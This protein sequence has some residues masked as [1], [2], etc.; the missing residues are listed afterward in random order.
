M[1]YIQ[2]FSQSGQP[3]FLYVSETAPHWPLHALPEDIDKY[4]TTYQVGWDQIREKRYHKLVEMG[5][6]DP[7][8]SPLSPRINP[9]LSWEDNSD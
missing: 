5:M 8:N 2:E 7:A 9:D 4:K 6:I 1:A 3:F